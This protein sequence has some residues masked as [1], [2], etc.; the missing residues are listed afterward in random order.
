[1]RY[2]IY[3]AASLIIFMLQSTFG[4]Y[5]EIAGIVPNIMLAFTVCTAYMGSAERGL[6]L[7]IVMGLLQD[8]FFG[9]YIGCNLFLYGIIG[10]TTG[11]LSQNL[12][13]DNIATSVL[14]I[15]AATLFYNL[16]FFVINILLKGHTDISGYIYMKILPETVYNAIVTLP[17][18]YIAKALNNISETKLNRII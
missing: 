1:M 6:A 3:F 5:V 8:C 15:T 2:I 12:Y 14:F 11:V 17:V 9:Y 16:G 18:F 7:G 10:Y 13:K 4:R